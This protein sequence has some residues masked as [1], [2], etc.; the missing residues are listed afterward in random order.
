MN[1]DGEAVSWEDIQAPRLELGRAPASILL[2][3]SGFLGDSSL[4]VP[5]AREAKRLYPAARLSILTLPGRETLFRRSGADEIIPDDKRGADGG[6]LGILKLSRRLKARRFDIALVPHRSFRSALLAALSGSRARIGFSNSEGRFLLTHA[7][8]FHWRMPDL[9]RQLSLLK[10]LAPE[11]ALPSDAGIYLAPGS[12]EIERMSEKLEA[13]G[14][15]AGRRLVGIHAGS[16][17]GTKRWLKEGYSSLCKSLVERGAGVVLI[18]G[19]GDRAVSDEIAQE[20]GA[21]NWTGETSL[22]DLIALLSKLSLFVT[23]DSGPMHLACGLG[24]KTLAVFGPTTRALGFFPYGAGHRVIES[25]LPCRPCSLHGPSRCPRGHFL[26]MRLV[27]PQR[28]MEAAL[29][30]LDLG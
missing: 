24:V 4:S 1:L 27:T 23:N 6:M 9:E 30:M 7:V 15:G 22:P 19:A 21:L 10:S 16:T 3:Q 13:A 12:V 29:Q 18:G 5:L 8:P 17:W 28:V 2:I 20:S 11:L 26:C 14:F 25:A